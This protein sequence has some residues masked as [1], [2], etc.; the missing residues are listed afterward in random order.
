METKK[1]WRN[2]NRATISVKVSTNFT[3][4]DNFA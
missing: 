2:E 4:A 3:E 1:T